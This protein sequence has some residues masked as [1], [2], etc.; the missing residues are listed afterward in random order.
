VVTVPTSAV[1]EVGAGRATVDVLDRGRP[2]TTVVTVGIVGGSRT[3]IVSG[4]EAGQR[5]VLADLDAALPTTD[6][7]NQRGFGGLR[8]P[9][10]FRSRGGPARAAR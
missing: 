6:S 10:T 4:L 1:T 3:S 7:A 5:V 2:I 8:G 9:V